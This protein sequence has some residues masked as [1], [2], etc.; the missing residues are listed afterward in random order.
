MTRPVFGFRAPTMPYKLSVQGKRVALCV[1]VGLSVWSIF[2]PGIAAQQKRVRVNRMIEA[3]EAGKPAMGGETWTFV[4]REHRP[5]DISELRQTLERAVFPYR[6][7]QGQPLLAPVV[8]I[9]TEGDQ[10]V[11]WVIKQVLEGGAMGIVIPAVDTPDQ[12]TRI[13]QAMRY[14]QLKTSPYPNP[15]GR[16]GCGCTGGANWGLKNPSDYV[17]VADVWPLNPEGEL[18][19]LPMIESPEGVRNI[20]AILDVPG[21]TGVLVGPTDL[22]MN[23]GEGQWTDSSIPKP[24]TLAAIQTVA[25]ACAAKKKP[26]GIATA[27]ESQTQQFLAAGFTIIHRSYTKLRF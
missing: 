25:K 18:V 5:Y 16:R 2:E 26:C 27:N 23:H 10:G 6:A 14:P 20:D 17:L 22:S 7:P 4:D 8:R 12:A 24:D 1:C 9:P 21:V 11:R 15:S 13:V 19:A 3:L